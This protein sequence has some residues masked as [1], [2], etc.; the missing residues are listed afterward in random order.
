[1]TKHLFHIKRREQK[2]ADFYIYTVVTW[3]IGYWLNIGDFKNHF[4]LLIL[5]SWGWTWFSSSLLI[6]L[7]KLF[8]VN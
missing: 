8:G 1:M 2:G 4:K 5:S 3:N 6:T 7:T